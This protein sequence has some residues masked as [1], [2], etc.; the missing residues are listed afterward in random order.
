MMSGGSECDRSFYTVFERGEDKDQDFLPDWWEHVHFGTMARWGGFDD[1]DEDGTWN[2]TEYWFGLNPNV[3]DGPPGPPLP[4]GCCGGGASGFSGGEGGESSSYFSP[5]NGLRLSRPVVGMTN[6][7]LT[8]IEADPA[9]SY[10]LYSTTNL[11]TNA[12]WRRIHALPAGVTNISL[13]AAA[14]VTEFYLLAGT[15]DTDA[16]GLPD[17]FEELVSK[18]NPGNRDSDGDGW[19]DSYEDSNNDGIPNH[20]EY[21]RFTAAVIFAS[22]N[23][24]T[25][26][27]ANGQFTVMLPAPAPA[28]GLLVH[29]EVEQLF[30]TNAAPGYSLST[31]LGPIFIPAGSSSNTISVAVV[32]DALGGNF[33]PEVALRITN[34]GSMAFDDHY[35][36]VRIVEDDPPLVWIY[37]ADGDASEPSGTNTNH[38]EFTIACAG[39]VGPLTVNL[40]Y[41]GSATASGDYQSLPSSVL[42]LTGSNTVTLTV[43]ILDDTAFEGTE[44]IQAT[45]AANGSY[46]LDASN[47]VATIAIADNDLPAVQVTATDSDAREAGPNTGTF[48]FNRTGTTA[49]SLTVFY[50][51]SG[52]ASNVADYAVIT[53]QITFAAGSSNATL[54]ITP[55]NDGVRESM[56]TVILTLRGGEA[57]TIGTNNRAVVWLDDSSSTEY[58]WELIKQAAVPGSPGIIEVYRTGTSRDPYN[59]AF[60]VFS[61]ITVVSPGN[62]SITG[63]VAANL[64]TFSNNASK[65]RILVA[66]QA[67]NVGY[68]GVQIAI[69]NLFQASGKP[70][71]FLQQW[72]AVTATVVTQEAVENGGGAVLRLTRPASGTALNVPLTVS[73]FARPWNGTS[74]DHHQQSSVTASFTQFSTL[75]DVP[76]NAINDGALEGFES[77]T[78]GI[79]PIQISQTA[80]GAWTNILFVRENVADPEVLPESD[81][82]GDGLPD[83]WELLYALDPLIKDDPTSD[84]D[85]D[86]LSL[87]DEFGFNTNPTNA[88]SRS[89]NYNDFVYSL[90]PGGTNVPTVGVRLFVEGT[91]KSNN[92]QNCATCHTPVLKVGEL[93]HVNFRNQTS[94]EKLVQL[95]TGQSYPIR[96]EELV[97]DLPPATGNSSSPNTTARYTAQL[98]STNSATT[99]FFIL[100][101]QS[102]LGSNLVWDSSSL[103]KTALVVV[104]KIEVTLPTKTN[105]EPNGLIVVKG[106]G[107]TFRFLPSAITLPAGQPKWE[108]QQLKSDGSW[109][110]WQH[111]QPNATG[112]TYT[113]STITGGV[114]RT[115]ASLTLADGRNFTFQYERTRDERLGFDVIGPGRRGQPDVFGVVD[116]PL[117][118]SVS[119][120]AAK[121][122]GS[123]VYP[124]G[125][126]VAAQY[127]F[128]QFKR[129]TLKCNIFVAHRATAAGAPVPPIHG[130][131]T[132]LRAFPPVANEWAGIADT[133]IKPGF[134]Q[135]IFNWV[136]LPTNALPQPGWIIAHPQPGDSGHCAIHDYDG[137]GVG[138]GSD[139]SQVTKNYNQFFDGTSRYRWFNITE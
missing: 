5:T 63:D 19:D 87:F 18:T 84:T 135:Y 121:F 99:N 107:V 72:Q 112:T 123:K 93:S 104:P 89:T 115:R 124:L 6:V 15:T 41:G 122:T 108:T 51:I 133:G 49:E 28:G 127:G 26:G 7:T 105:R 20:A 117:Q 52:T 67:Y 125:G 40:S 30:E 64:V 34:A 85:R 120:E 76:F 137:I 97:Q 66:P 71:H 23:T 36:A 130:G 65:A 103:T 139:S 45:I 90:N 136:L 118:I 48:T 9:A 13:A 109:T 27:G 17:A 68:P 129:D 102:M 73:G 98:L 10:D 33:V 32:N 138:A 116:D 3:V 110:P 2:R 50:N 43:A 114:F 75:V 96:L 4:A 46:S 78:V 74:G 39:A 53:N 128:S 47:S 60:Q 54:T 86:G 92:G 25:E 126:N 83:R 29:Y 22:I 62:Y 16:D 12:I 58:S 132:G 55:V 77:V 113:Y 11:G 21:S 94:K 35:A 119:R 100:D 57:Y 79:D 88:F 59:V 131:R 82:D 38:A 44:I 70:V 101:P 61:N 134:P 106:E 31:G 8:V 1:P 80:A 81:T 111:V 14:H 91:G 56:E 24:A 95:V 69:S 42:I 37:A